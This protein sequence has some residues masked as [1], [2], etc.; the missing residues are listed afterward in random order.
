MVPEEVKSYCVFAGELLEKVGSAAYF[1][2]KNG[3]FFYINNAAEKLDRYKN[4][5]L[6]GKSIPDAYGLDDTPL[7]RALRQ[8]K[9]IEIT[10]RYNVNGC[11]VVQSCYAQ[12]LYYQ[13]EKVG[14]CTV[15][16][17]I[18]KLKEVVENNIQLQKRLFPDS[19][20]EKNTIAQKENIGFHQVIGQDPSFLAALSTAAIAARNSSPIMIFGATGSG[21]E[22]I[23]RSIHNTSPRKNKPFLAINCAAIPESLLESILFGTTKGSYTGAVEKSGLFE[24]AEGGTLFLDE[25]NSMPILSQAKLLRV[26]EEKEVRRLG[27][28]ETTPVDV[29]IISSSNALPDEIFQENI[30][31]KDLFYRLTVISIVIPPLTE[32]KSD[33][34]VLT[35]YF[36]DI[37]N[38]DFNKK[39]K[40]LDPE[41]EKIFQNYDWPG[42]VRQ[43]KNCLESAMNFVED[44]TYIEKSLLPRYLL[45]KAY[46]SFS[47]EVPQIPNQGANLV[48]INSPETST[49]KDLEEKQDNE[50][51]GNIFDRI[52]EHEKEKIIETLIANHGN[53]AK[54]ARDLNMHRQSLLYRLKKYGLK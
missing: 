7:L 17:D 9:Q 31:R 23:A 40:G 42:N 39:V 33:I 44:Q 51:N 20:K 30:I 1:C 48:L 8:E 3:K 47:D 38:K 16:R 27:A 41:A 54:T 36:I 43:L 11:E 53:V 45:G 50:S 14:A 15:Q 32:R 22:M 2:D 13:G 26:L 5:D 12:P 49:T 18:T 37:F 21:K 25:I 52:R 6:L 10:F 46:Y 24:Q 4:N 19:L 35:Q 28:Q 34:P 29:R